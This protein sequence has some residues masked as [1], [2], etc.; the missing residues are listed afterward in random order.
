MG[1][2]VAMGV[3]GRGR[4]TNSKAKLKPRVKQEPKPKGGEKKEVVS[5]RGDRFQL[6]NVKSA[7]YRNLRLQ[8]LTCGVQTEMT[9]SFR[10]LY[11][12]NKNF[13]F[14]MTH[15]SRYI[16]DPITT[17]FTEKY[18]FL[19]EKYGQ[20]HAHI[21]AYAKQ[22]IEQCLTDISNA[23]VV[24]NLGDWCRQ[25]M[26]EYLTMLLQ[27][28]LQEFIRGIRTNDQ[29]FSF[30]SREEQMAEVKK[31]PS[32]Q[33]FSNW[34]GAKTTGKSS[35]H[36]M[37][38]RVA[39]RGRQMQ[40][41]LDELPEKMPVP[42]LIKLAKAAA[43]DVDVQPDE[44]EGL[45]IALVECV[46]NCLPEEEMETILDMFPEAIGV[47]VRAALKG[48]FY[49]YKDVEYKFFLRKMNVRAIV[50]F[51]AYFYGKFQVP[52]TQMQALDDFVG[53]VYISDET[54]GWKAMKESLFA[55]DGEGKF[56]LDGTP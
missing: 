32:I 9:E 52:A 5:A 7:L 43:M 34:K 4:P 27:G 49:K 25:R 2:K 29:T 55:P 36:A 37:F 17:E 50:L 53:Y 1:A 30:R 22:F 15:P 23:V 41:F 44:V 20:A 10:D 6:S 46:G 26:V 11:G 54:S 3:G 31:L 42:Q 12:E 28:Y 39:A 21:D 33:A 24:D 47:G 13:A 8:M 35:P 18:K 51:Y 19:L 56:Q 16:T 48:R 40:K 45:L 38:L 14:G